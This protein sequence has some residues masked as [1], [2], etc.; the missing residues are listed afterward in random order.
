MFA[1]HK[2]KAQMLVLIAEAEEFLNHPVLGSR[3]IAI[4]EAL[5][6]LENNNSFDGKVLEAMDD[7]AWEEISKKNLAKAKNKMSV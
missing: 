5:L 1:A 6:E 3:L 4:C 7:Q 2:G